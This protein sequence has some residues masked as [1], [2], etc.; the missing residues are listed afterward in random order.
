MKF[1]FSFIFSMF[2]SLSVAQKKYDIILK[3]IEK[4]A[5]KYENVANQIWSFA[6]VGY[7]EEKS[8][9]LLQKTLLEEDV[10]I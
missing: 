10:T 7:Q 1:L 5:S 4:G 9:T 6:E 2:I 3:S 8:S